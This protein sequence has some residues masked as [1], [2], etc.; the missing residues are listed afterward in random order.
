MANVTWLYAGAIY[1]AAVWLA[2]RAGVDL[3]WKIA[4][5][6]YT[7]VFIFL[8]QSLTTDM[9]NLPVD[10]L[11]TLLP[12]REVSNHIPLNT[13]INDLA[14]QIVPWARQV[15][16]SWKSFDVPLWN[17]LA[18]SGYPLLGNAQSS[19]FSI[20]RLL[21]L[22]LPLGQSFAA[23]AA[24]KFLIALTFT[25]L[26]CKRRGYSDLASAMGAI[27]F[28]FST[29]IVV[30]LHF[31]LATASAFLPAVMYQVD[32]LAERIT[33][34]RFLFAA[35]LWAA[36]IFSGHP[37]TV[38][39][40]FFM[41]LL[42]MLW[43]VAVERKHS[44]HLVLTLGAALT[45]GV[46][47]AAPLL[48]PFAESLN[49]SKRYHQ[50]L[51][52]PSI[53]EYVHDWPTLALLVQPHFFGRVESERVWKPITPEFTTGFAGILGIAAAIA[54]A[55][56]VIRTRKW[57]SREMFFVIAT[58]IVLGIILEWPLISD[59]FHLAFRLAANG[60]LRLLLCFLLAVQ[61]AAAI[62]LARRELLFGLLVSAAILAY[63]VFAT[64]FA[65]PWRHDNAVLEM[66]PSM[67]VIALALL[68]S[69][70]RSRPSDRGRERPPLHIVPAAL[71]TVAI[72][73]ELWSN[74][75][76]WNPNVSE[77]W[78]YPETPLITKLL[79]LKSQQ[80]ANQPFRIIGAGPT[81]FPN[82]PAIF[83][84][85]DVRTHDPMANGRYLGVLRVLTGYSTDEYFAKW[86]N[87][88]TRVL[89]FLNVKYIVAPP[90]A[91]LQD[92]ARYHK[93]Y[94]ARDGVIFE[95]TA[96]LPRFFPARNVVLEFNDERFI[97]LLRE[98]QD[99]GITGLLE[100]LPVDSDRMRNDLLAPR[101]K[102]APEAKLVINTVRPT[103]YRMRINAPRYTLVVS[104]IP[105][106][107]GWKAE[108]NGRRLE[109][110]RVN[111]AFMGF[112]VPPGVSDL[113]VYYAP[114]SFRAGVIASVVMLL[115]LVAGWAFSRLREKVPRSGG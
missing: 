26:F 70:G 109:P 92:P 43:I 67:A 104:S 93:V 4:I 63:L 9:V 50:L 62:D 48:V 61:V 68:C 83:G 76:G 97:R 7:L 110:L 108:A 23:E 30:W 6:F 91:D 8:R 101:P 32:L 13:Q 38:A 2:R 52:N 115:V 89:D 45:A 27:S 3:P 46:I 11:A 16:E 35:G 75:G 14:L 53:V 102:T 47:L 5:F 82:S 17:H 80:P 37:E 36:I 103:D 1:A 64:D 55:V 19:A 96:V 107:P 51:A 34:P 105:W 81:F 113:R 114:A 57:R 78:M 77:K 15:R 60:R 18:G 20:L 95:N 59:L 72:I 65:I 40:I 74:S 84:F 28:A 12:W 21:A 87:F 111:G 29:F 99:W 25:W 56:Y 88:E 85:E 58:F 69:G 71:L 33:Y 54:L 22:P 86:R 41:A 94:D 39:H 90:T 79:E 112:T 100:T 49:K 10:Y 44:H 98:H 42:Y 73:A 106:W 24:M 31:P 66:I